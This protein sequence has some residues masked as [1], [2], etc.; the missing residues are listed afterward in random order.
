MSSLEKAEIA[1]DTLAI[2][3]GAGIPARPVAPD[4]RLSTFAP[5]R[6]AWAALVGDFSARDEAAAEFQRQ[7]DGSLVLQFIGRPFAVKK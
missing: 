5:N 1:Q 7:D 2:V 4:W 3:L 6:D